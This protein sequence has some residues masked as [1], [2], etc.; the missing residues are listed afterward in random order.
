MDCA[1]SEKY[2]FS[3]NNIRDETSPSSSSGSGQASLSSDPEEVQQA[4]ASA[5]AAAAALLA[6]QQQFTLVPVGSLPPVRFPGSGQNEINV[7][8]LPASQATADDFDLDYLADYLD[9]PSTTTRRP[10]PR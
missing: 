10:R 7:N 8:R 5:A 2:Y 9:T 6:L 4:A 1:S 3:Q